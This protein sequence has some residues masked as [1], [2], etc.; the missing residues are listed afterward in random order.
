MKNFKLWNTLLGWVAFAIAAATYLLTIEPTASFWDCG[1]FISSAYKL[2]VGHPPGAPFFMLMGHFASLFAS[3]PSHVAMCVNALSAIMSALTILFLFWTITA[4]ARKLVESRDSKVG[5]AVSAMGLWQ[6]IAVLGAGMVGALA[7]TFSD[8]FWFS[9][10]EGEV[11]ASSSFFTAVVFW[12]ILKWDEQADREGSD[13]WLIL[14]AYLMGLSIGV[15]LLN[16]LTIPAIV[17]VYYFRR[18]EFSWGG[19]FGALCASGVILAGILY[20]I[21]PGLPTIAGWFELLFTNVLGC[22]FNTGLAVYIV[23]TFLA[24][25]WAVYESYVDRSK[26]REIVSFVVAMA[27]SG[28]LF[29]FESALIGVVLSVV[30]LIVLLANSSKIEARWLNTITM[31]VAVILIG[32]SSY[33]AL[34]IRSAADTPMDQNSPDNVFSL[35]YYLNREQY[36][37]RPLFY[38]QTYNAPVKLEVRGNMCIPVEKEGHAQYAPAPKTAGEKDRYV[39]TGHKTNYVFMDE[40]MMPFPRMYSSQGS[41][42]QAYK[43]WA[44]VKGK[45]VRYDYC[46]QKK[47]EYCPTFVENMRFFFRY[48]VNFMYWRYFLW[49]FSGRQNDL[50]SYGDL[51]KGNWITGIPFI[52]N[53]MLGDQSKLP[54]ELRE[55]KGHNVY[56]MLPLLLGLIGLVWQ[57]SKRVKTSD[58]Q[59]DMAGAR[60]FVI[61]F[62][63]FFLTGLAIVIYLNQTPYQPR[64]RD[65][66]YAGSFYAFCIWIGLG[67]LALADWLNSLVESRKSKAE[68]RDSSGDDTLKTAVALCVTLVCLGVPAL[69]AQQ[70]WDDHDR[71]NRYSCRDFGA[72]Y[73][74]SCEEQGIIFSNGDNDTFPLWYNQEV[75]GVGT[76]LR[77]CNLSY[78]QTDWYISQMKRP[79]YESKA[80]PIS[81]EYKDFMPGKNEVVWVENTA[82]EPLEVRRAFDFLRSDNPRTKRDGEN[83]IPSNKLFVYGPDSQRIDIKSARRFTRSEMMVLE[84]LSENNWERPMYFAVTVGND[85]YLGLEPYFECTGLAYRITPERSR[86]GHPRIN[87]EKMYDNMLHKFAYGNMNM[88]G[89]YIDENLMRMC[90]T[91]RMMFAEL[92]DALFR[93]GKREQCR[94]VLD[95]AEEMLPGYNIPYDYTSASMAAIYYALGDSDKAN[96]IMTKVADNCTE[97]LEWGATLDRTHYKSVQQQMGHQL[98]VL[99]Y[100]LQNMERYRQEE[101]LERYYP[102]YDRFAGS[103]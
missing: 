103:R 73:L 93:E 70:N 42:V 16:L 10:V 2:D 80:L 83:Y 46:G 11:Y 50:Q 36:G 65:Y 30:L 28:T 15:H 69:M 9:A 6:G 18:Y 78:L 57:A 81:W 98:A 60:S 79:Y 40:F 12:L 25:G 68:G 99:G 19:A 52:D 61:T 67:V 76:D 74:K 38:G 56:Y 90:R 43:D 17:L 27:L 96:A 53:A 41:H 39:V 1:E 35:K 7:Y 92:A 101:L 82:G 37:D 3:D 44:E 26:S 75:E 22:P 95:Y 58:G 71:S 34:V 8:T 14:I 97:Y 102:V 29:L 66:A 13:K 49:N 59:R 84:M 21:I 51:S 47:T 31:M 32:Y 87:T 23:L 91:H 5:S 77:V 94:E 20:G 48:Q 85:Y 64:E 24:L 33:A 89:I 86:D 4:L 55:N 63:L 54:T 100:A 45:R 88:P 62:L 72:N